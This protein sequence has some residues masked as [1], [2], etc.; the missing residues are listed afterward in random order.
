[1]MRSWEAAAVCSLV[2]V[3]AVAACCPPPRPPRVWFA[4]PKL[5]ED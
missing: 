1:M 3:V 2:A 4:T 5:D